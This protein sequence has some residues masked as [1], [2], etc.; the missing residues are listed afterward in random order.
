[1]CIA[2]YFMYAI[3]ALASPGAD[4][5]SSP[6]HGHAAAD[7]LPR[8]VKA[9][10]DQSLLLQEEGAHLRNIRQLTFGHDQQH[11]DLSEAA[12]YAEAYWSPDGK[13]LIL[14]S[15]RNGYPCDQAYTLDLLTG[16]LKLVSTGTGRVTCGYF[17]PPGWD[18]QGGREGMVIFSS[19]HESL[20]A[21]CP[22]RA[23]MS[24][25]YVWA[26]Y[27]YDIYLGDIDGGIVRNLTNSPGYDA[28]GTIDWEGEWL[29]FT[30]TRDG[31]IDIYRLNLH[32]YKA[33]RLTDDVGYDGGPFISPDGR[34]IVYR[35]TF[36]N[37]AQEEQEYKDLLAQNLVR[38]SKLDLMVMDADG[39][40]KRRLTANG[41][42]NFAPYLHPDNETL[43]FC[44]N[45]GSQEQGGRSF[46]LYTIPLR[47]GS[48]TF[49]GDDI[50]DGARFDP[51]AKP[52]NNDHEADRY[53]AP[54][55]GK[56]YAVPERITWT[57]EFEGFPMF[58]PDGRH[59]VWCSNR[60]GSRA[61][62]TNVFVAEWLP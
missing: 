7:T 53:V 6:A 32:D 3:T 21:D 35:R 18:A 39:S 13:N 5:K 25:G 55:I 28:E 46:D 30:S 47:S 33:E 1:M 38:P 52:Y 49:L 16:S 51:D 62:E 8:I 43:I 59:L 42:A 23:D 11:Q 20:G 54:A 4:D 29:Y 58:S 50:P 34:Q 57:G 10:T 60:N 15:T 41:A 45:L 2:C 44:S 17:A 37:N 14:Q 26:I 56:G 36:F 19:T 31:D 27:P 61:R 9:A 40:N 12:N 24:Q 48:G 22:P